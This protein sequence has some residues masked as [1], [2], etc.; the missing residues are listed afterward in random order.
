MMA[1][2]RIMRRAV[3]VFTPA[4]SS[5]LSPVSSTTGR[6]RRS[7]AAKANSTV[8]PAGPGAARAPSMRNTG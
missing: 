6:N 8:T 5:W 3:G 7:P 2:A 4:A 1:S